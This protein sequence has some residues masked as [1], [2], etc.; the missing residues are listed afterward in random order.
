MYDATTGN[1]ILTLVDVP[2]GAA[3]PSS[4]GSILVYSLTANANG[5]A[6]SLWNSSQAINWDNNHAPSEL[7]DYWEWRPYS[8]QTDP[9]SLGIVNAT[10]TTVDSYGVIQN[11]NG[12]MWTVE[13][14]QPIA[15][16]VFT[17][18]SIYGPAS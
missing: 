6:L 18:A 12:T 1:W 2:T 4:D 8:W 3:M 15:G 5:Y 14:P 10:G 9:Y 11:T 17:P 7:N 13:E 16:A